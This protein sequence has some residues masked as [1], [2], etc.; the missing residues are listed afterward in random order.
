MFLGFRGS[1]NTVGYTLHNTV[2][3]NRQWDRRPTGLRI[4]HSKLTHG[5][6]MSREQPQHVKTGEESYG[7]EIWGIYNNNNKVKN[8]EYACTG[9]WRQ[10]NSLVFN[11]YANVGSTRGLLVCG[12]R[13][14]GGR[15]YPATQ[16]QRAHRP[17]KPHIGTVPI[18]L[19]SHTEARSP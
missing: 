18:G 13:V 10:S 15:V 5:H 11:Q 12:V 9:Y 4:G 14:A 8:C 1:V 19:K 7:E 3:E 2:S 6:F 17:L 16:K